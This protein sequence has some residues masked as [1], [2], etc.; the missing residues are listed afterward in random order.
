MTPATLKVFG[1][2]ISAGH[3]LVGGVSVGYP[4]VSR[5]MQGSKWRR[6]FHLT[7]VPSWDLLIVLEGLS[8]HPFKPFQQV[9]L[10]AFSHADAGSGSKG[11]CLAL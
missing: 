7:R 1:V 11:L 5:F 4:L 3:T 10:E 2:A 8:S 6:P 9:V